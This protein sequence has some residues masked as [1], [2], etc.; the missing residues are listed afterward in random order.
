ML[1]YLVIPSYLLMLSWEVTI[2][3]YLLVDNSKRYYLKISLSYLVLLIL[4]LFL[5]LP[6]CSRFLH[7]KQHGRGPFEN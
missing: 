6:F 2:P 4:I 7:S 1:V 3:S 5:H